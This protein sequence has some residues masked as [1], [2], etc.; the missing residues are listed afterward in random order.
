MSKGKSHGKTYVSGQPGT[1]NMTKTGSAGSAV[2]LG[3][4]TDGPV[5][6]M[7]GAKLK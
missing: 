2:G 1:M 5:V 4:G 6:R 3:K 7:G